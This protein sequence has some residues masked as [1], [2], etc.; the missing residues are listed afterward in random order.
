[1][2]NYQYTRNFGTLRVQITDN[3]KVPHLHVEL[4]DWSPSI[5]KECKEILK[6]V[7]RF[8]WN[9]GY[10]QV[11]SVIPDNDPKL[12]KFQTFFGMKELKR[13]DGLILFAQET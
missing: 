10:K 6:D 1:M 4:V 8:L 7:K 13:R 9:Q 11:V 5:A 2:I 12:Y 3:W